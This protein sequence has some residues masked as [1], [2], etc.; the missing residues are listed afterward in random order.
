[1]AVQERI[2]SEIKGRMLEDIVLLETKLANHNKQI[3]DSSKIT[4][5]LHFLDIYHVL[6][7]KKRILVY[8]AT[9]R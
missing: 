1:M 7:V 2:L 5:K 6:N 3:F 8:I 9:E 4:K